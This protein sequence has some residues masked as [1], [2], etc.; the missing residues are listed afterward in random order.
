MRSRLWRRAVWGGA[1]LFALS[2][3]AP[4]AGAAP[5]ST[6]K[7]ILAQLAAQAKDPNL[8]ERERVRAIDV[9]GQWGT[10]DVRD[11]LVALLQDPKPPIR[12]AAARALGWPGHREAIP[13]LRSRAADTQEDIDVRAASLDALIRIGDGAVRDLFLALSANTDAKIRERALEG[14]TL[15]PFAS[16]LDRVPLLIKAVEDDAL[17]LQFR[18]QAIQA[19]ASTRDPAA[20]PVCK[21]ALETGMR[22]KMDIPGPK[23]T[24]QELLSVRYQQARDL[25]AWAARCLGERGER[26]A[27]PDL[28][29]AAE[30]PDDFF[31]RLNGVH[32]LAALRA[33]EARPVFCRLLKDPSPDVRAAAAGGIGLLGDRTAID[34][35]AAG[36]HDSAGMVRTQ[37]S[38]ALGLLGGPAARQH[39]EAARQRERDPQVVGALEAALSQLS[40]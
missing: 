35:L 13:A 12:R 6:A 17:D 33:P 27:V 15:G 4:L 32:A 24:Q 5:L 39:L 1:L 40:P 10:A 9:L 23:A 22:I 3:V 2:S 25:R 19:L 8:D 18:A 28:L 20:A 14:L 37:T 38:L 36:L 30:D 34:C 21:R 7:P 16:P 31:L 29:K 26:S 11:P